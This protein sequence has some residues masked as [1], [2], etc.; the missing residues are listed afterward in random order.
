MGTLSLDRQITEESH[1]RRPK[2]KVGQSV[3][4][5]QATLKKIE[6]AFAVAEIEVGFG[7]IGEDRRVLGRKSESGLRVKEGF[8]AEFVLSVEHGEH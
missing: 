1:N 4:V 7:D 8:I 6:S 5:L 3:T 2:L